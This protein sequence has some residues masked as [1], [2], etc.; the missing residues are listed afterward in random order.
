MFVAVCRVWSRSIEFQSLEQQAS[1]ISNQAGAERVFERRP[2]FCGEEYLSRLLYPL[3][4]LRSS[5]FK[6]AANERRTPPSP[7]RGHRIDMRCFVVH[8]TPS[9]NQGVTHVC[10]G[11]P[12]LES[13]HRVSVMRATGV[14]NLQPK[15]GQSESSSA[16]P[17]S[18]AKNI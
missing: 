14:I 6:T 18:V 9:P 17:G 13:I 12:R 10:G 16:A 4:R 5:E 3:P 7:D 8:I 1:L 15:P 11:L 2:G